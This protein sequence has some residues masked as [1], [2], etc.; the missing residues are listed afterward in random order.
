MKEKYYYIG[1]AIAIAIIALIQPFLNYF[2]KIL[3]TQ[4][5]IY[6]IFAM[7]FNILFGYTGELSFGHAI[8]FGLG[9]TVVGLCAEHL[10]LGFLT[11]LVIATVVALGAAWLIGFFAI[12]VTG[13]YFAII[14]IIF[15]QIIY[16]ATLNW[17][18]IAGGDDGFTFRIPSWKLMG[19]TISFHNLQV[20]YYFALLFFI[21]SFLIY[22][23]II[24]SPY[25]K[26]LKSIRE[27]EDRASVIGYN[28]RRLKLTSFIISGGFGGLSGALYAA[29]V[30]HYTSAN[31]F[32]IAV[33]GNPVI[34]TLVGGA[35]TIVGPVI[36]T[37]IMVLFIHF[38]STTI[39]EY[40][41]LIGILIIVV[42]VATPRG[43]MGSLINYYRRRSEKEI[44]G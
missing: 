2:Y 20:A 11:S 4:I 24:D 15:S 40:L 9:A 14:T 34:W 29:L 44:P 21:L 19:S 35:G 38:I 25:G 32:T 42:I 10:S 33:S 18:W 30:S 36:G 6:S 17:K 31:L 13:L 37:G 3:V 1:F 27:N 7:G 26:V 41:M 39:R 8:F 23:R 22:K 12:R 5:L 28:V 43:I 16:L